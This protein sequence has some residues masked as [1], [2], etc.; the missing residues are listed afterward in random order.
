MTFQPGSRLSLALLAPLLL[1]SC[2]SDASWDAVPD[3]LRSFVEAAEARC[4]RRA[5]DEKEQCYE[6]LFLTRLDQ[7]GVAEALRALEA[8]GSVDPEVER[9]GHMYVHAI[10][11][12]AYR[13]N[14]NWDETFGQCTELFQSGCYHGVIQAR[15]MELGRITADDVNAMCEAYRNDPAERFVLFQCLHGLGHGLTMFSEH[16]LPVALESCDHLSLAWDRQSCYGGAFMENI[17]NA[18]SPHHLVSDMMTEAAAGGSDEGT[19]QAEADP[20]MAG[21]EHTSSGWIGLDED[22]PHYPCSVLEQ[23]YLRECYVMQTSAILW[24]NGWDIGAAAATCLTAPEGMRRTCV[25]SLGRD[26]A[27]HVVGDHERGLRECENARED[28]R[29]W[30]HV[31]FVKNL[32]DVTATTGSAF[33]FCARLDAGPGRELCHQAIG[34]QLTVLRATAGERASECAQAVGEAEETACRRAAG[35]AGATG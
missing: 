19:R 1:P 7:T 26:I 30:C 14:P 9:N 15:F 2:A 17:M 28:L 23:R 16:D 35:V 3:D 25:Q 22:D 33:A 29:P 31:G 12:T 6:P 13:R 34:E 27:G 32:I 24:L 11:I 18:T 5:A 8:I 21:H 4:G 20:G 10:G